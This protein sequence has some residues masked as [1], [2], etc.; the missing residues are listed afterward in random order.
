MERTP[1]KRGV[2][3]CVVLALVAFIVFEPVCHNEFIGFDDSVYVTR[4]PH[5]KAGLSH[6]TI[7]WSFSFTGIS[8]W[9]PLTWLSH[10]LDCQLYGLRPGMHHLTNLVL[11]IANSLLLFLIFKRMTGALW[12]S[13]FV[14]ALFA[15]HPINVDSVAWVAERK[16]VLS[17][18]FWML[19][20]LTYACYSERPGSY[21]Y[22]LVFLVFAV[23]L[24]AK[25]MLVT[26]PF[27]L[28]LL[29]YWPLGRLRF[30]QLDGD[31][32]N[33]NS[34][35]PNYQWPRLVLEKIP[36][37]A[38]SMVSICLSSLSLQH[39][40]RV[41]STE[42]APMMLR[43]ANALVSYV[44]YIGNM[45]WP[46][47]LAVFYP[48]PDAIPMWQAIGALLLLVCVSALA[49]RTLRPMPYLGTGWLWYIGTLI[50]V[51][52]LV[53]AGLWPARADRF[54]YVPLIGLFII[55]TWG[56]SDALVKW[57]YRK[58]ALSA[59]ALIVLLALAICT[60]LQLRHWRNSVALFEHALAVTGSNSTM[61]NNLGFALQLQ[62][63]LDKAI[64]HY[65]QALQAEP[66][67]P[68]AHNN[69]GNALQSQGKLDEAIGHYRQALQAEPDFAEAHYNMG[70]M[71]QSQGNLDE[72]ISHY[73]Q[74]L[75]VKPDYAKAHNNLA[76]VLLKQGK[77]DEAVHHYRQALQ[78]EPDNA[79]IRYNLETVLKSQRSAD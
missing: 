52:G 17:T 47:N 19:T 71:L 72:A 44:S 59:S 30:G 75:Q 79:D 58:I 41:I 49:I 74:A 26:L 15:L 54:A 67:H 29:D 68:E 63:K 24:L 28:L 6:D 32:R 7:A 61:H 2:L 34:K 23:G 76:N 45:L 51:I 69:L 4:N 12:R 55:I 77:F 48:Y 40:R 3:I 50:P 56:L 43:T 65:Y 36:L 16:N 60:R 25:P 78:A 39:Y 37:L 8:Y 18:F 38:L 1:N 21:R 13:A 46:Q 53:Q 70:N 14:A 11:H 64:S 10:S 35:I 9:Q 33:S 27:V 5:V 42:T 57:R 22:L 31:G 20:M 73:R 62:G 66:D